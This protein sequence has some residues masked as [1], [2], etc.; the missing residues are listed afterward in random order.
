MKNTTS[1]TYLVYTNK[2][3]RLAT[4]SFLSWLLIKTR[5]ERIEVLRVERIS[6]KPEGFAEMISLSKYYQSLC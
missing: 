3:A 1:N 2:A 6:D 5:I 4:D